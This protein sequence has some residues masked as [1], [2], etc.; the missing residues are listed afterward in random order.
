MKA[1]RGLRV[2]EYNGI[3]GGAD[4]FSI[5]GKLGG[6]KRNC[7]IHVIGKIKSENHVSW[8]VKVVR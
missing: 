2:F 3:M 6:G 8:Y 1:M 5:I 4:Y 7:S